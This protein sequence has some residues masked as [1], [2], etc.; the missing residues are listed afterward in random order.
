MRKFWI[1]RALKIT[2]FVMLAIVAMGSVVMFLWNWLVPT[3]FHGPVINFCQALGI[4]I[5]SKI[6]FGGFKKGG[7]NR[8]CHYKGGSHWRNKLEEKFSNM[9]PEEREKLKQ[10]FGNRCKS[11]MWETP[12]EDTKKDS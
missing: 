8:G 2:V 5:L 3:L 10:K 11:W 4:L 12:S 9:S 1:V 6:L 7:C